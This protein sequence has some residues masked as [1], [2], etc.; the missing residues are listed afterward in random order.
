[1]C[2]GSGPSTRPSSKT[3][4]EPLMT[5]N[6]IDVT[7]L[8][9]SNEECLYRGCLRVVLYNLAFPHNGKS[10]CM[11]YRVFVAPVENLSRQ[12]VVSIWHIF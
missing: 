11:N 4:T 6:A 7:S 10:V 12:L 1:M 9:F 8:L 3:H 2:A 5:V